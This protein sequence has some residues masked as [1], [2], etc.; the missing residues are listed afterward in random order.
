[1][2]R[3][4]KKMSQKGGWMSGGKGEGG[5]KIGRAGEGKKEG[6]EKVRRGRGKARAN[7][8]D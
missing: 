5:R 7:G 2:E 6:T 1:M 3:K 8:K 4:G